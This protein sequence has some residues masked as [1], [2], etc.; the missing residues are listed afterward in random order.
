MAETIE[1]ALLSEAA[2]ERY[3]R[4]ALSVITSRALP[5]VRDGLKPVQRRILYAMENDLGLGG[6]DAKPQKCAGVVGSV[7]KDYHP[8]GDQAI[9]DT[10]VRLAQDFSMRY[11]LVDGEGNFGSISGDPP[12]AYRYTECR[13]TAIASTTMALL[14]EQ[15]V[16]FRPNYA[17]TKEEPVVLPVPAPFLLAN[18]TTGIA[19]GMATNVPP[20]NLGELAK[21]CAHLIDAPEATV[22]DLLKHVKGPDFPTSGEV[23]CKR[24]DLRAI[25][26]TGRGS[27]KLRGTYKIEEGARGARSLVINSIP[28][29]TTVETVIGAVAEIIRAKKLPHALDVRNETNAD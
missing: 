19:V 11:R 10:M 25:Y 22:A 2:R 15:T 8:H 13:L 1:Q 6:G 16:P 29:G 27:F 9:Y 3:L 12:A 21:A 26:E 14:G 28:Y 4:Y 5:D 17:A 18:G 7:M 23:L 20:H 24:A